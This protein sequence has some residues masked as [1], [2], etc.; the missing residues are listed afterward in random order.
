MSAFRRA[1]L[2]YNSIFTP[3]RALLLNHSRASSLLL[4]YSEGNGCHIPKDPIA[5]S[6]QCP[7]VVSFPLWIMW[8]FCDLERDCWS[9]FLTFSNYLNGIQLYCHQMPKYFV[10][11]SPSVLANSMRVQ[12]SWAYI[13]CS[14]GKPLQSGKCIACFSN[15]FIA[16]VNS[17]FIDIPIWLYMSSI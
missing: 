15:W 5:S 8:S 9:L 12:L 10:H 2:Q 13:L 7:W 4:W 11:L 14:S 1:T 3:S 17:S 6:A 16:L